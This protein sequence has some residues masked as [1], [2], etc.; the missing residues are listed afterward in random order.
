MG[1]TVERVETVSKIGHEIYETQLR[2]KVDGF[3]DD[4]QLTL[5]PL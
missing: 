2:S 3:E 4:G 1:S 5:T